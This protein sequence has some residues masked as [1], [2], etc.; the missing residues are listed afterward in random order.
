MKVLEKTVF[1][2]AI[3]TMD[4]TKRLPTGVT[5]SSFDAQLSEKF[6]GT[7]SDVTIT[8]PS[9]SADNKKIQA[10]FKLGTLNTKYLVRFRVTWSD[11]QKREGQGILLIRDNV[12]SA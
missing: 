12:R 10:L 2:E 6:D 1:G 3:F 11:A 7:A 4:W 9:T 8:T 5:I